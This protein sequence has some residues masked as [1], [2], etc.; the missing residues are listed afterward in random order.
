[1]KRLRFL[2]AFALAFLARPAS[3]GNFCPDLG[4]LVKSLHQRYGSGAY[5]FQKLA[6]KWLISSPE[7]QLLPGDVLVYPFKNP[8][9]GEDGLPRGP[10]EPPA[11]RAAL[12][13]F[14]HA[15]IV[16]RNE[17][18][19]LYHLDAPLPPPWLRR[20]F[21]GKDTYYVVRPKLPK[22]MTR[23]AFEKQVNETTAVFRE[24][25]FEYDALMQMDFLDPAQVKKMKAIVDKGCPA[26]SAFHGPPSGSPLPNQFCSELTQTILVLSGAT[27]AK[28]TTADK[29]MELALKKVRSETKALGTDS[30]E[31]EKE[32]EKAVDSVIRMFAGP[33][34]EIQKNFDRALAEVDEGLKHAKEGSPERA[35]LERAK[36]EIEADQKAF[37]A[38]Q[39]RW[40]MGRTLL[41]QLA[42]QKLKSPDFDPLGVMKRPVVR[43]VDILRDALSGDSSRYELVGYYPGHLPATCKPPEPPF[44]GGLGPLFGPPEHGG[45]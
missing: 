27:P 14:G 5:D 4:P 29:L 26:P 3:A 8:G 40:E 2:V 23:E 41:L 43:P 28:A 11:Y 34:E 36:Q 1:M 30:P 17:K 45:D 13:G 24:L 42:R 25:G 15:G 32:I 37:R 35:E 21:Q 12:E 16:A 39:L 31:L 9:P 44:G 22:G 19:K 7:E 33:T 38:E 18:G 20:E 6:K 10:E